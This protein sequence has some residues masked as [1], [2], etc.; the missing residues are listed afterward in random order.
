MDVNILIVF[1][2]ALVPLLV[3]FIWYNPKVFGTIWMK[4]TGMT[5]ESAKN[6]NMF[7]MMGLT[8][9]FAFLVAFILQPMVIHQFGVFSILGMQPDSADPNSESST[10]FKHFMDLYGT[11]YRTFK[12]GAFHGTLAGIFLITPIIGTS[13]L[14]EQRSFKYVAITAGYWI[15]SMG[16]MGGILCAFA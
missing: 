6:A 4:A 5:E 2:A 14:Y 15:V 1:L 11:S 16:L 8:F 9:V 3:G 10:M 7:K 13:A 12:H